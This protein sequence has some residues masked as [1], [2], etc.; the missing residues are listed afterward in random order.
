[1]PRRTLKHGNDYQGIAERK[2]DKYSKG[3]SDHFIQLEPDQPWEY[4]NHGPLKVPF[5]D[6][7]VHR[8][9]VNAGIA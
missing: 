4:K 9:Q 5:F 1:M 2:H 6:V 7:M 8:I 3:L